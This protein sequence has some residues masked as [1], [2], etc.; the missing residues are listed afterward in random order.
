VFVGLQI[1]AQRRL[2]SP[3]QEKQSPPTPGDRARIVRF[4]MGEQG[5]AVALRFALRRRR[6]FS[7]Q[8]PHTLASMARRGLPHGRTSEV[9]LR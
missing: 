8:L 1:A 7:I 9:L 2:P 4:P 3:V 6:I 5:D